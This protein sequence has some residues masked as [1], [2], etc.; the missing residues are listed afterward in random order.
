MHLSGGGLPYRS[1]RSTLV[2]LSHLHGGWGALLPY[3]FDEGKLI[4]EAYDDV[5]AVIECFRT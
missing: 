1:A 5:K 2:L 4:V 3:Q